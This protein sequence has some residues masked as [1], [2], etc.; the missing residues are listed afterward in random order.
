MQGVKNLAGGE[1]PLHRL[2]YKMDFAN[3]IYFFRQ[4]LFNESNIN[5]VDLRGNTPIILAG[6][7]APNND[8]YLKAVHFFFEKGANGKLRDGKGWSL[9]DEAISQQNARLLAIVFDCLNEKKKAKWER[10]KLSIFN[11][12]RLI[13]DF[14]VEMHWE[15]QSSF[16]PFLS[17]IAPNDT[18]KIYKIGSFLRLDF[19]LVGFRHLKAKRRKMTIL[20]RDSKEYK[21]R[22]TDMDILLVNRD[23]KIVVNPMEDLDMD[24]KLAVL[25]DI[26]NSDPIQNQLNVDE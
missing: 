3:M 19:S 17:K 4:G 22:F 13:P 21:D 24:E 10:Q 20:F 23:R 18:F 9:M 6:K 2:L 25:T 8:E 26:I 16:I 5:E 7:L 14:S 12:L 11:K 1:Y 15:C